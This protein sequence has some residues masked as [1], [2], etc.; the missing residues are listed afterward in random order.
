MKVCLQL[1]LVAV[2]GLGSVFTASPTTTVAPRYAINLD[3]PAE[4][5][6]SEVAQDFS[7]KMK[8]MASVVSASV[9][10]D[11]MDLMTLLSLVVESAFPHPYNHEMMGIA[12]ATGIKIV[13]VILI[14]TLY[15]VTAY[16][17]GGFAGCTSIVAESASGTIFHGR[18]LDYSLGP[19]LPNMTITV[20]FQ[21][22]GETVYTGTTFAGYVGLLTGQKPHAYTISMNERDKGKWWMNAAEA[23]VNGMGAVAAIRI[24]ETLAN[25]SLDYKSALTFLSETPFIAP[26]YLTIG[27]TE[28]SQGAVITRDRSYALDVMI[29]DSQKGE[30][31]VL[32]TNYDHW[33]TP[34]PDD[35]RRDPGIKYMNE[36]GRGNVS[37]AGLFNVLSTAPVLNEGTTYTVVMS[38]AHPQYYNSWIR[39]FPSKK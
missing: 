35:D 1:F 32:E 39:N 2:A 30:W 28:A 37:Q 11:V 25:E 36:M 10:G 24:R 33:T 14:N 27:G 38:A 23:L 17:E 18:N 8:H 21:K 20:D 6:W 31:F 12:N 22:G 7:S 26:C 4:Q 5:R 16:G 9:P 19:F 15:E 29:I 34:P 13:D 3:L